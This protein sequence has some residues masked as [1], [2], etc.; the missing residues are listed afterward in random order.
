M[1]LKLAALF[2]L[3]CLLRHE[4]S[5]DKIKGKHHVIVPTLIYQC[6]KYPATE[7]RVTSSSVRDF[8]GR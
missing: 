7:L 4:V 2:L 5:A 8:S 3:I 1:G 6:A